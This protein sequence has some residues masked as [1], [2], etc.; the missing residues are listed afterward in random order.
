MNSKYLLF[1]LLFIFIFVSN[2]AYCENYTLDEFLKKYSLKD[3]FIVRQKREFIHWFSPKQSEI[4]TK[5]KEKKIQQELS[6]EMDGYIK[7]NNPMLNKL[8]IE[9]WGLKEFHL[10]VQDQHGSLHDILVINKKELGEQ[11]L[12]RIKK[13]YK[14]ILV[15]FNQKNSIN[16]KKYYFD[17][18]L[19]L[20]AETKLKSILIDEELLLKI[21]PNLLLKDEEINLDKESINRTI[22]ELKSTYIKGQ[23]AMNNRMQARADSIFNKIGKS[24]KSLGNYI[25]SQSRQLQY[26]ITQ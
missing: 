9:Y 13:K 18:E 19:F 15:S 23:S 7:D 14:D 17:A 22:N 4:L 12:Q 3:Y 24:F 11:Y 10:G 5:K 6:N 20:A 1:L 25:N 21:Y 26:R 8:D 16:I 2:E